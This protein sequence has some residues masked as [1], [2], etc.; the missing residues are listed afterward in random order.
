MPAKV[1][2]LTDGAQRKI[3]IGK[4]EIIFTQ[5]TSNN[6]ATAG[7]VSGLVIQARRYMGKNRVD[8]AVIDTLAR[9]LAPDDRRRLMQ[10]IRY[11]PAWIGAVFRRLAERGT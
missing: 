4:Q 1:V 2:F 11:A 6:M 10:D 7:R 5:T 9:R 3:S 8:D